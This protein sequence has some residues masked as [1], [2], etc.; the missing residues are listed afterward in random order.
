MNFGVGAQKLL[1]TAMIAGLACATAFAADNNDASSKVRVSSAVYVYEM[2]SAPEPVSTTPA[3]PLA[4]NPVTPSLATQASHGFVP[5]L[6][7]ALV[8]KPAHHASPAERTAWFALSSFS[9]GAAA[10]DAY[11]TRASLTSGRG[12]ERN[13]VMAP[14]AKS[15]A[16]YPATQVV[17]FG[18]DYLSRRMMRSNNSL[19]R[20]TWWL[21][22]LASGV[23]STWVGV[24]NLHV[25]R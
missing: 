10:F 18:L 23:G 6:R 9:H 7:G 1:G 8:P 24:R 11:S 25:A 3:S 19:F 17:P 2:P 21:P 14:F 22:Q 13:P 15:A 16:I 20:H 4:A 5:M 12:Y